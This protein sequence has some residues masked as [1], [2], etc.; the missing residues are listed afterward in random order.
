MNSLKLEAAEQATIIAIGGNLPGGHGSSQALLNAALERLGPLGVETVA[1][2]GWWRSEAWPDPA[3]PYFL[4]A[5]VLARTDLAPR[6]LLEAL[7]GLETAFGRRRGAANAPRTLD[8][9]LI[10]YGRLVSADPALAVPHPRAHERR[11]VMGPLAQ[12][13]PAWRHPTLGL[14]A[15][16]L[17]ARAPVG[18]DAAPL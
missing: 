11:F 13:A 2:S 3:D 10:A 12:I 14:T 6:A 8:L 16:D 17:A 7:L 18:R 4:N 15:A 9:D 5:V 1:R